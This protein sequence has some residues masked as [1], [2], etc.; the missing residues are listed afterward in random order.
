MSLTA[1]RLK[2]ALSYDHE[3]GVFTWL[4]FHGAYAKIGMVAGSKRKDG[5]LRIKIDQ[6]EHSS[7]RLAWLYVHGEWPKDHIDH[8]NGIRSDNR[9]ENLRDVARSINALNKDYAY[10]SNKASGLLG[11]AW[12][13]TIK[14]WRARISLHGKRISI[15]G[16]F[17]TPEGAHEA[18]IDYKKSLGLLVGGR[19]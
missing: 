16:S 4:A 10:S 14:K 18:Y 7:H 1:E 12:Q 9:I 5:Y 19:L 3:T 13:P 8:I 15:K 17:D 6:V 11:V 2:N